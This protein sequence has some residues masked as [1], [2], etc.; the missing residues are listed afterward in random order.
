[1]RRNALHQSPQHFQIHRVPIPPV[2]VFQFGRFQDFRNLLER[3]VADN[4]AKPFHTNFAQADVLM[5]IDAAAK[6]FLGV[7]KVQDFHALQPDRRFDLLSKRRVSPAAEIVPGSEEV[8]RVEADRQPLRRFHTLDN[9]GKMFEF[10][11]Q[12]S[13]LPRGDFKASEYATGADGRVDLIQ[14]RRD[15]AQTGFLAAAD[16]RARVRHQLGYSQ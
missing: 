6:V 9:L 7:V 1:M 5:A 11:S 2:R 12:P 10:V 13:A 14:S 4:G 16:V 3:L 8:R 15:P